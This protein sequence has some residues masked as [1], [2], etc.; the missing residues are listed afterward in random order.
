MLL[1]SLE[2]QAEGGS[3]QVIAGG[4]GFLEAISRADQDLAEALKV[5]GP[6]KCARILAHVLRARA[7][8]DVIK[9]DLSRE[10]L[11]K[12]VEQV[13]PVLKA[14]NERKLYEISTFTLY[15]PGTKWGE[16]QVA[17]KL[18]FDVARNSLKFVDPS[19]KC[20]TFGGA[21][22]YRAFSDEPIIRPTSISSDGLYVVFE[23]EPVW[24]GSEQ[25]G[26]GWWIK[27]VRVP[28]P[29]DAST[30]DESKQS[31]ELKLRLMIRIPTA[32]FKHNVVYMQYVDG[33]GR[34]FEGYPKHHEL[35]GVDTAQGAK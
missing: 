26:P 34:T 28:T 17:G 20:T 8:L 3:A 1:G 29:S 15:R 35:T 23:S 11:A 5:T 24:V 4:P 18:V 13:L 7:S 33:W 14:L 12:A 32:T 19:V 27:A 10:A 22:I 31:Q 6:G 30:I 16:G 9:R 25:M 2:I 21:E